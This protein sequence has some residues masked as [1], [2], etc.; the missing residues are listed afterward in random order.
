LFSVHPNGNLWG[1]PFCPSTGPRTE[2]SLRQQP[3]L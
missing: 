1:V 3:Q 2:Q